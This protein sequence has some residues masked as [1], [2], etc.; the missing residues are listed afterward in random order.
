MITVEDQAMPSASA[1]PSAHGPMMPTATAS[2]GVV[3]YVSA[4]S[5]HEQPLP[6]RDAPS[7]SSA[8]ARDEAMPPSDAAQLPIP[9]QD[10]SRSAPPLGKS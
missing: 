10:V 6:L 8:T 5:K 2:G 4:M 3:P 1:A 9:F 7:A